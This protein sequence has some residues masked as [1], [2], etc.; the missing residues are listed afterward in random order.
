MTLVLEGERLSRRF[1]GLRVLSDVSLQLRRGE[2]HVVTG[3]HG[4]GKSTLVN[5]LSGELWLRIPA[6]SASTGKT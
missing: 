2:L 4:A 1:G 3:P 6:A 5:L